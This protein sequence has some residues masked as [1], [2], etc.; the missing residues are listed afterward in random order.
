MAVGKAYMKGKGTK[1]DEAKAKKY[2][3]RAVNNPKGGAELLK[4]VREEAAAGDE[5]A[6]KIL[7]LIK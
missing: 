4:E 2:L 7:T 1:A 6:K 5:D 3:K